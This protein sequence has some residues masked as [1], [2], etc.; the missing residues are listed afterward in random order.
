MI[1]PRLWRQRCSL[2]TCSLSGKIT[3]ELCIVAELQQVTGVCH[4]D[5]PI[6]ALP[7]QTGQLIP[8]DRDWILEPQ[9][10]ICF[11]DGSSNHWLG[12]FRFYIIKN[13]LYYINIVIFIPLNSIDLLLMLHIY[14]V[15]CVWCMLREI[16]SNLYADTTKNAFY[17]YLKMCLWS[18]LLHKTTSNSFLRNPVLSLHVR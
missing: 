6:S 18:W 1:S 10:R 14:C 11:T 2:L 16:H 17:R 12:F 4:Y 13:I 7:T 5:I 3:L 15:L 9:A 8:G